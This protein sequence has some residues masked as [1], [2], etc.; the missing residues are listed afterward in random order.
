[1]AKIVDT[2]D[3]E[4]KK[5]IF[6]GILFTVCIVS[7][8]QLFEVIWVSLFTVLIRYFHVDFYVKYSH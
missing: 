5:M 2:K 1:M 8:T 3:T 4:K 6:S 7:R